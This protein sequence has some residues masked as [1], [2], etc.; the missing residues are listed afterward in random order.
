[1]AEIKKYYNVTIE[2]SNGSKII[3][4][5]VRAMSKKEA[6]ENSKSNADDEVI[7][8]VDDN[9]FQHVIT[10]SHIVQ[11]VIGE[12]DSPEK[13]KEEFDKTHEV[14]SEIMF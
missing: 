8:I 1:M 11:I 13:R 12:T 14:L 2:L 7:S 10:K 4:N 5:D 3:K 9:G 6:W